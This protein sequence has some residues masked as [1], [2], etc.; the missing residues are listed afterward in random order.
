MIN[1]LTGQKKGKHMRID[2]TDRSTLWKR[3]VNWLDDILLIAAICCDSEALDEMCEED[4][5]SCY[6]C[7]SFIR[8]PFG[9]QRGISCFKCRTFDEEIDDPDDP[10]CDGSRFELA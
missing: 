5:V 9:E 2:K 7:Q 1:L 8:S 10:M 3:Y 4:S 6:E